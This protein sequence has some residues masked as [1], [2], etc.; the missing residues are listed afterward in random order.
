[1]KKL[2]E[3]LENLST[4][5]STSRARKSSEVVAGR[6][7]IVTSRPAESAAETPLVSSQSA[8]LRIGDSSNDAADVDATVSPSSKNALEP[9]STIIP[10]LI[11]DEHVNAASDPSPSTIAKDTTQKQ[12]PTVARDDHSSLSSS[13][14]WERALEKVKA[15][16]T[17]EKFSRLVNVHANLAGG[18]FDCEVIIAVAQRSQNRLS[19]PS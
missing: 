7:T 11:S 15:D 18:D 5:R 2:R 4:S 16:P 10:G 14:L 8:L 12:E 13:N 1:M 6:S 3:K 19:R 9:S 17:W